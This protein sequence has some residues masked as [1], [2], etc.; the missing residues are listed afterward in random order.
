MRELFSA[1]PE[2]YGQ[3]RHR[4]GVFFGKPGD[5]LFPAVRRRKEFPAAAIAPHISDILRAGAQNQRYI[6]QKNQ[7]AQ[8]IA[9]FLK[10]GH[11]GHLWHAAKI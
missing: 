10:T 5:H 7:G 4:I 8:R 3:V 1:Q 6:V 11:S 2:L 9:G